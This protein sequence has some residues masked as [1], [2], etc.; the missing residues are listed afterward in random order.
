MISFLHIDNNLFVGKL[1]SFCIFSCPE[2]WLM[3]V[4]ICNGLGVYLGMKTCEY[5]GNKVKLLFHRR[6]KLLS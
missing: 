2:Q 5:L 4:L 3:D 6:D 1:M